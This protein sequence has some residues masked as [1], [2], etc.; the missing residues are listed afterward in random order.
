MVAVLGQIFNPVAQKKLEN[1]KAELQKKIE[2]EKAAL[3]TTI[4]NQKAELQKEIE[5]SKADYADRNS[6]KAARRDYEYEA[7][8]RLYTQV[9]PLFLQLYEA[10]DSC[11]GRISALARTSRQHH[12]GVG[13]GSWIDHPG[14]FLRSTAYRVILPA[15]HF[16]IIQRRMTFV[17]LKLDQTLRLRYL[18][19]KALYRSYGDAFDFA[20]LAPKLDYDPVWQDREHTLTNPVKYPQGLVGGDL[21][22]AVEHLIHTQNEAVQ[23]VLFGAF[24]N[25]VR[26]IAHP[27]AADPDTGRKVEDLEELIH[28]YL[29]F[30]P[31]TRPV[32]ARMLLVQ[33]ILCLLVMVT[34]REEATVE[35]LRSWME[36]FCNDDNVRKDLCWDAGAGLGALDVVRPY[37]KSCLDHVASAP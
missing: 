21:D 18:L 3:Q 26:T 27:D 30:S 5:A 4:E 15:V 19:L 23:P 22:N 16:R 37:L 9:E 12:L 7:L 8:K 14:Y 34:Y 17:D 11:Y 25:E 35:G 20:A 28:L 10:I 24:E 13:A 32:L 36:R 2:D 6:A 1:Q 31:D 33:A 29:G